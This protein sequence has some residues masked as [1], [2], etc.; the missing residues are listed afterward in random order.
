MQIHAIK[1]N[2]FYDWDS[3]FNPFYKKTIKGVS[4][5]H[6]FLYA[7]SQNGYLHKMLTITS[8]EE[9]K[10]KLVKLK[11]KA[12]KEERRVWETTLKATFPEEETHPGLSEIKQVELYLK[13]RNVVPDKFQDIMCPKPSD[14]V[15]EKIKNQKRDKAKS[16]LEQK[17]Q[18]TGA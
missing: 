6:C 5:Y 17:K 7:N 8:E 10:E 4:K 14:E 15:L 13:W 18:H 2:D 1:K 9:D 16:K 11:I 12:T 3:F